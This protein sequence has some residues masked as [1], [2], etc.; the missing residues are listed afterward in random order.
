M[1]CGHEQRR[2]G[3]LAH[4]AAHLDDRAGAVRLQRPLARRPRARPGSGYRDSNEGRES[5]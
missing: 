3:F 1:L 2:V 4:R 5:C